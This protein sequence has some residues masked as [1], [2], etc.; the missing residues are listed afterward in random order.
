[1]GPICSDTE[2]ET[3]RHTGF[4]WLLGW[5][6]FAGYIWLQFSPPQAQPWL[7]LPL[8]VPLVL[9]AFLLLLA[10]TLIHI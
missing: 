7:A 4:Y 6:V 2:Y 9:F 1:M 5:L 8:W 3:R 10:L